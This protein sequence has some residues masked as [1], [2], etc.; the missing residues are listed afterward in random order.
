MKAR[1]FYHVLVLSLGLFLSGCSSS[2]GDGESGNK[3]E[4][5][6]I[7]LVRHAEKIDHSKDP[8]LSMA[9]YQ[10]AKVLAGTLTDAKIE[11]IH[12]SDFIRTRETA[13][14]LAEQS[15]LKIELYD[16]R[17]LFSLSDQ[18]KAAGGRH[19]VVGHSNT[20]PDLVEI[21]GGD[22]GPA[23]QE[24]NE[25][26]RLYILTISKETV[27]TVLIRYGQPFSSLPS[28]ISASS[29]EVPQTSGSAL[30]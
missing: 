19:L 21:L 18:L 2:V 14:P 17:D 23:I 9:G 6:V 8:D 11:Y 30:N 22:P 1:L 20:T 25:Y 4:Q 26:D 7:F 28:S 5:L 10:R 12:S 16:P 27:N 24:E 3:E 15:G 13:K 29:L